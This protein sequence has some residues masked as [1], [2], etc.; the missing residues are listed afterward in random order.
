M[1]EKSAV[2]IHKTAGV[3]VLDFRESVQLDAER[4]DYLQRYAETCWWAGVEAVKVVR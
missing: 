3:G 4:L 2:E 1:A